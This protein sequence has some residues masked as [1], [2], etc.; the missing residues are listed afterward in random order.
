[1]S[2][3]AGPIRHSVVGGIPAVW[4]ESPG[5]FEAG[6]VFRVGTGDETL[7]RHGITRLVQHLAHA[8]GLPR[9]IEKGASVGTTVTMFWAAG[10]EASVLEHL[11]TIARRLPDLPVDRLEHERGVMLAEAAGRA[12][13]S[14]EMALE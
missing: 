2:W 8:P 9:D 5:Q 10:P 7:A 14:D 6:V 3:P 4:V 12:Q 11:G 13:D 1:M